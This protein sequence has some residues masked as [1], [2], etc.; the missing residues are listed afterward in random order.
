MDAAALIDLLGLQPHPEGGHF[1]E[2]FRSAVP[3]D[4]G[5]R[6]ASTA[7]WYLLEAGDFSSW[8]CVSSDEVWHHY[9]GGPLALWTL[10][11]AGLQ[12]TVLGRDWAAGERPQQPA[13]NRE[14]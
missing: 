2:T 6:A 9:D 12:R 7:I 10:S 3:I 13:S 11:E 1:R 4:G 5:R 14:L 8:H